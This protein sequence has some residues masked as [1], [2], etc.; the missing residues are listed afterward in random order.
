MIKKRTGK[1]LMSLLTAS[2]ICSVIVPSIPKQADAINI[3]IIDSANTGIIAAASSQAEN[4]VNVA[5]GEEG[6]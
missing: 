5:L 6:R 1:R 4:L 3:G 2:V